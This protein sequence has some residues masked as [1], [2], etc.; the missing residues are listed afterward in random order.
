MFAGFS[1]FSTFEVYM[2]IY[3]YTPHYERRFFALRMAKQKN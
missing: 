3:F 2:P 1:F